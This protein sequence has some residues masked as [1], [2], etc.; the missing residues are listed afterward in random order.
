MMKQL[1][2]KTF[3]YGLM[4]LPF[5][6]SLS[7][8]A[9]KTRDLYQIKI[10]HLK[11]VD[12]EKQL[13][14]YLK[15]AY[16]PALHRIKFNKIGVFKPVISEEQAVNAE[17]LVYVFIPFKSWSD[18]VNLEQKLAKDQRYITDGN[19]YLNAA[20]NNAPFDRIESILL[21]AFE[22]APRFDLPQLKSPA[23]ERVYELRSYEGPT[24]K[25]YENKVSMF[26]KGDEIGLFKRLGF[27]AIF[28]AEVISGARMPNLMY[29]T[30]FENKADR[31]SHW[32]TFSAD[33][34]WKK[35]S[36]MPE[37][38]HNVSRND[39]K[40]LYPADYSDI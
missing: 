4:L 15:N 24:E 19:E 35:L 23:K 3:I 31:E 8:S 32:K 37:Y 25:Y 29:L 40:F 14:A 27:N 9:Q 5:L 16:L 13:D 7:S 6:S 20:Y 28:Y 10:Y 11:S 34:Y 36:A 17:R 39:T 26:N 12:Q 22:G 18:V 21:M 1:N 33:A 2:L 30:A 38:Q